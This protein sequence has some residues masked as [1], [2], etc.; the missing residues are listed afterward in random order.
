MFGY[1]LPLKSELKVKDYQYFR[2]YYCG[3][4]NEIKRQY[5]N[6]PRFCLSYD[7]TF[8]GF[9]LEGVS[10][11][12][13]YSSSIKCIK[14]PFEKTI[15]ANSTNSLT[16][17][18]HI[19][20]LI[21]DLKLCDNIEDDNS[22]KSLFFHYIL[23]PSNKKSKDQ[24]KEISFNISHNLSIL[25]SLEKDKTFSSL[26]EIC[27]PFSDLMGK[28]LKDYPY[29]FD[30]DTPALR[31]N[32]YWLGYFIGKW[33]YLIDALDDLNDDMKNKKFNPFNHLYN[34]NSCDFKTLYISIYETI[35]FN[36]I[37]CLSRCSEIIKSIPFKKHYD[38]IDN[39]INLGMPY[40]YFEIKSK[41]N[42]LI[43]EKTSSN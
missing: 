43:D 35:D 37:N 22:K 6:L 1:L 5:G 3:L 14:H 19:S 4:C 11:T 23:K 39:V 18:A 21:F 8:I 26:D 17:M 34:T 12:P 40:K 41:I 30:D 24:L 7:L 42:N 2:A 33:I 20:I 15:I 32:L 31:E 10:S 9:L 36:I 25:S 27:E 29:S 13:L 16:Y 28:M 38:T